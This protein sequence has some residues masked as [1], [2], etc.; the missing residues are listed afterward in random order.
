MCGCS[1][2][3]RARTLTIAG[4]LLAVLGLWMIV[5]PPAAQ[6]FNVAADKVAHPLGELDC[7]GFS[8]RQHS[9][10]STMAC[11]DIRGS[12][13]VQ[14][15]NVN[16]GRFFDNGHYIG[17][18]E[19]DATFLSSDPGSGNNVTWI[20]TLPK[21]PTAAPTSGSPGGDITH[22][23]EL[24]I[25]PWFSMAMCDSN[26][27]PQ[28]PCS[29]K[30]DLN[31]P[32]CDPSA[33]GGCPA[34]TYPGGGSAFMEMQFYPPGF[35][36]FADAI[37]C[38]NQHW[39]SALNI[40][41]LECTLGFASCNGGCVEPVNFAYIQ[42]D[43]V[44][45]GP[46]SPQETNLSTLTPNGKTLLMNP[47][48]RLRIHMFDAAVPGHPGQRAFEVVIDDL[49]TH[50]SGFMQA[51]AANGFQNTS[52]TDCSGTPHNFEPEYN[53]ASKKGITPWAALQTNISTQYEIGHFTPCTNITGRFNIPLAPGVSDVSYQ[54]CVGPYETTAD[55]GGNPEQSDANCFPAGDTHG[56]LNTAPDVMTGCLD[57][58]S[59]GDID[60]DGTPYW[61][62]W[63][64]GTTPG[65]FPSS[66]VQQ[67]PTSA[68]RQYPSF[69]LQTDTALSESTC[70]GT[71]GSGCAIPP[72]DAPG[73]F[74]PY[75]TRISGATCSF[76]FGNVS[77]GAGANTYGKDA[78]Y[79][80]D[81]SA[82]IG[83]PEFEGP[84]HSNACTSSS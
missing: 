7:N 43:G 21:D 74:F 9:V 3:L 15:T 8:P 52:I 22:W 14:N 32:K 84:V 24:S 10:K 61:A 54:N 16:D 59:G 19:P 70:D 55:G 45:A 6:A 18:D 41:S 80:T 82:T 30:N 66:F 1:R 23:F 49:T 47:G 38:D 57:F 31:A 58:A 68:G 5:G 34:G 65:A 69:F 46:P 83:Y 28:L 17:H 48:D 11:T 13:Q 42:R 78:Q 62:D 27:Y 56:I 4:A 64:T 39:C 50:Q 40:D 25:A 76:E 79:G 2:G 51:S 35:A 77:I 81:Q 67:L 63:P 44:P 12:N 33:P 53:T 71:T 75:W 26:S 72:P 37:S 29:P 36:P 20:E 73:Q 60:F